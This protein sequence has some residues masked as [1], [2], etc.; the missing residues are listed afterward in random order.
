MTEKSAYDLYKTEKTEAKRLRD[1]AHAEL[2]KYR[3]CQRC[4]D[5]QR[6]KITRQESRINAVVKP[7]RN[8]DDYPAVQKQGDPK[9]I[10]DLLIS[11]A[12]LRTLYDRNTAY[13]EGRLIRIERLI[14][15]SGLSEI[16]AEII[17]RLYLRGDR[18]PTRRDTARE[19]HYSRPGF[20]KL[21]EATLEKVG[22]RVDT[23]RHLDS[24]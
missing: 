14:S 24:V 9:A 5:R 23:S 7:L 13:A 1:L 8:P 3:E 22:K 21:L 15:M 4:L 20:Y 2:S 6:E 18:A 10:E 16:Q 11:A 12:E 17:D 19:M